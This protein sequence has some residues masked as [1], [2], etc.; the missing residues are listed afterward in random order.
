MSSTKPTKGAASPDLPTINNAPNTPNT[1]NTSNTPEERN[2]GRVVREEPVLGSPA[3]AFAFRVGYL[4][5]VLDPAVPFSEGQLQN[6]RALLNYYENGGQVPPF[7]PTLF[8]VNG[9][10]STDPTAV[11]PRDPSLWIE[12]VCSPFLHPFYIILIL[13]LGVE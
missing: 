11:D 10:I 13:F 9:V 8:I 7:G 2:S 6:A 3:M 5:G 1:S 4:K 12:G